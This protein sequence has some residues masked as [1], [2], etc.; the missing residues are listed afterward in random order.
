MPLCYNFPSKIIKTPG[1]IPPAEKELKPHLQ[2]LVPRVT[3]EGEVASGEI[4]GGLKLL[5]T[6]CNLWEEENRAK[7]HYLGS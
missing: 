1:K 2:T 4:M 3:K 5:A 7:I 6:I